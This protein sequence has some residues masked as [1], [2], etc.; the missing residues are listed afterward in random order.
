MLGPVISASKMPIFLP[1]RASSQASKAVMEDLPTPPL[2]LITAMTRSILLNLFNCGNSVAPG[3]KSALRSS[4]LITDWVMFT[5]FTPGSFITA[6]RASRS[7]FCFNGQPAIV[8]ARVKA[9][10][11]PREMVTFLIMPSSTRLRPSSG[12]ITPDKASYTCFSVIILLQYTP[13]IIC[14]G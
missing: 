2:P 3:G 11:P 4:S 8:K 7:I 12:S 13:F 9:T 10:T 14:W 1:C 5:C 6:S